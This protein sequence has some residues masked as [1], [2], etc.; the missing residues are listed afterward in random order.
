VL[1]SQFVTQ[2]LTNFSPVT[3]PSADQ[4]SRSIVL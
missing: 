4:Y 2:A 1:E 3:C